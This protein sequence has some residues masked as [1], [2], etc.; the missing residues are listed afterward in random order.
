M[1]LQFLGATG[2]VTGSK[3]LLTRGGRRLLVDCGL[4][5]GY[6]QLRLRN[7]APLPFNPET[8][9]AVV[10]THAHLD[11]SGYLPLLVR[12]GFTG[13][14]YCTPATYDLCRILLPDSGRI[15]EEDAEHA[16]RHR[17]S[18]HKLA[19]PLY[20]EA[21]AFRALEQ[22][23]TRLFR[24][25]FEPVAGLRARLLHA[26][27]LLGS[28]TVHIDDGATRILFSGDLGRP[29]DL[30][31][32]PPDRPPSADAL[33]IE[34]T[35]GDRRHPAADP[36]AQ[37]G[38][39]IRRVAGRNGVM[40]VP[41]FTVG[42]TQTLLYCIERLK[43]QNA[44]AA[45]LPVFLN[46]P[47][48]VDATAIYL[49]HIGEHRLTREQTE[50]MCRTARIVNTVEQSKALNLRRGPMLIVAGSGMAT[51]GRV[52]HHLKAFAAD[53]N[54]AIIFT[55][56]QAGGTRGAALLRGADSIKI[57]GEYVPVR[58]EITSLSN[59]SAHADYAE[60]LDWL[61]SFDVPP[62]R[63]FIT[64]GEPDAADA[65]RRHIGESLDWA[66]EVPDYRQ[67]VVLERAGQPT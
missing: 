43:S 38:E 35:Y 18:K 2:T 9:G 45:D 54:N 4:F 47:M 24:E 39:V 58:A 62:K 23:R 53:P 3:Y 1:Q 36:I 50:A 56:F 34:S 12:N 48:A 10:L 64:H 8:L 61:R 17:H 40:V 21:D 26:G 19:L 63:T 7:W 15:Q 28:A 59:L 29:H 60:I 37:L 65:L 11:H 66:C 42:R 16:N 51:G 25:T 33:V 31:M 27:H 13:P 30:L 67:R 57:H 44:I 5:Q 46:S 6:K 14:I 20:T 32:R 55:G 52:I 41:A 22:F 49:R